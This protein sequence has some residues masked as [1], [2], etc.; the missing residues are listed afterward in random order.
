[1]HQAAA[2]EPRRL[3]IR[4]F[5][6]RCGC[7]RGMFVRDFTEKD[8]HIP[9]IRLPMANKTYWVDDPDHWSCNCPPEPEARRF[10][11][12][13]SRQGQSR[14]NHYILVEEYVEA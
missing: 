9:E 8:L 3:L 5:K 4:L 7:S 6:T 12:R 2:S 13:S 11:W 14:R 1:M 10:V